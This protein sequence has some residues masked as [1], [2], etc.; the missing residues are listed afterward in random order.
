MFVDLVCANTIPAPSAKRGF[1]IS[2]DLARSLGHEFCTNMSEDEVNAWKE[3]FPNS[4]VE[5]LQYKVDESVHRAFFDQSG[6]LANTLQHLIKTT[7]DEIIVQRCQL[8]G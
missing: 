4:M 7:V 8:R 5:T 6:V 2:T 1:F 3:Q